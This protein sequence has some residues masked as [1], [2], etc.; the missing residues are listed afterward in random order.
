MKRRSFLAMLGFAPIAGAATVQAV[1]AKPSPSELLIDATGANSQLA[2]DL[3]ALNA[4]ASRFLEWTSE[5]M[6]LTVARID[7]VRPYLFDAD[8]RCL[9]P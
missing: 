4:D 7:G 9:N 5:G 3:E 6:R 1:A 8:G 2:I